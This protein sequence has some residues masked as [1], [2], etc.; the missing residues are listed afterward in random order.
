MSDLLRWCVDQ[1]HHTFGLEASDDIVQ[2]ILSI[3]SGEEIAEYVWDLL[4]GTEGKKKRWFIDELLVRWQRTRCPVP[5]GASLFLLRETPSEM[6]DVAKD[7][8]RK[9]KRKGRNRQE[10][11]TM[12][13]PEPGPEVVKTPIDLL[14]VQKS[15]GPSSLKKKNKFVNLYTKDGQEKLTILLPGRHSC[16]CLAQKHCLINNCMTCGRIVCEQ[17]GSGPC[18]FCGSL[19]VCTKEE[20][21]ILQRDSNKSQKLRKKLMSDHVRQS[22]TAEK[23]ILPHEEEQMKVGLEK[24]L[25][26]RDKLLE[27]DKNSVQ[28]T[29]V[30]DDESDYFS[31]DSNQWLSPGEREALCRREMELLELRHASRKA[32]KITL[33]FAGRQVLE[34]GESLNQYYSRFD[35]AVQAINTGT[36][37]TMSQQSDNPPLRELLNPNIL[38]TAPQW[39]DMGHREIPQKPQ[40]TVVASEAGL[41]RAQLRLQDREL[42][43]MFDGG[44]CLSMHQPWA[45]LLITGIKRVEGRSWYTTHRGRLWIAA[46]AK[47]P[48]PQ[49]ISHVEYQYRQQ[50]RTELQFPRQYPTGCLLGCV[51]MTDCLSQEQYKEQ[52]HETCEDSSSPFM[53]I[54]SQPQELL[55]K[56]PMKGKHKIWKLDSQLH[57]GARKG[58]MPSPNLCA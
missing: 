33:D 19:Q 31:T 16:T 27:F 18:L 48:T 20:Q 38:Q 28:R 17:E 53:F 26:H 25:Q 40:G 54:C 3:E 24:A 34:E 49:E 6:Q 41:G 2:Y 21:K 30:L 11:P 29:Q 12:S 9:S 57:Q 45:S 39:V 50:Y 52:F 10:L 37:V 4:Q 58:L 56:F 1:L 51:S 32:R 7:L 13:D 46:A 44:W 35:E 14:K 36:M 47:R 8:L 42:Q 15:C 5:D 55:I 23:E 22:D 43:E